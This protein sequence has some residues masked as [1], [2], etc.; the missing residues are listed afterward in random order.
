MSDTQNTNV[1]DATEVE[2]TVTEPTTE[3]TVEA[4]TTS[5]EVEAEEKSE[6]EKWKALSK[7][8]EE[9][10]KSN[11]NQITELENRIKVL[12]EERKNFEAALEKN[13]ELTKKLVIK[14]TG[15]PENAIDR[16]RGS[17]EE[18]LR[19]DAEQ[20]KLLFGASVKKSVQPVSLHGT[21]QETKARE[22][23]FKGP[24]AHKNS[25]K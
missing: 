10:A 17:T 14:D 6:L 20:L 19:E 18:E 21:D 16:L 3:A 2:A 5:T 22:L 9:R 23:K 1:T 15:L 13:L 11:Y 25:L 8:N 24:E 4:P 7:K 12:T